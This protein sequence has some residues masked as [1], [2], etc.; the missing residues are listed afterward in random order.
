MHPD[1]A[2]PN[3]RWSVILQAQ[4]SG[5]GDAA[6]T[7]CTKGVFCKKKD[8]VPSLRINQLERLKRPC[9]DGEM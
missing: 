9:P 6:E 2:F 4:D 1:K 7:L 8:N 5:S 3:T